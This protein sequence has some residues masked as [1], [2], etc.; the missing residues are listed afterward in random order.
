M[1]RLRGCYVGI[2]PTKLD[3]VD[4]ESETRRKQG[5]KHGADRDTVASRGDLS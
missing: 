1:L 2:T 3:R 4:G 5:S